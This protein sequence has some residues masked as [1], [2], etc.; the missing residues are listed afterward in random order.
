MTDELNNHTIVSFEKHDVE[1]EDVDK[2]KLQDNF[3]KAT[4]ISDRKVSLYQIYKEEQENLQNLQC[5]ATFFNLIAFGYKNFD[6]IASDI[7]MTD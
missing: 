4:K 2:T 1:Q 3:V 5:R 6:V 7:D